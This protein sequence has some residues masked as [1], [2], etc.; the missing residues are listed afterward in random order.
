M[1]GDEQGMSASEEAQVY[2]ALRE[3]D[4]SISYDEARAMALVA[5]GIGAISGAI[6]GALIVGLIWWLS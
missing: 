6:V 1:T 4:A 5:V 3:V 2:A